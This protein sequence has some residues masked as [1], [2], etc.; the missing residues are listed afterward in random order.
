MGPRHNPL[1]LLTIHA[2]RWCLKLYNRLEVE[3]VAHVPAGAAIVVANHPSAIDPVVLA[4]TLPRRRTLFVAAA[5]F[6]ALPV[7]GWAMRSYGVIPVW[8]GQTDLSVIKDAIRALEDGKLVVIFPEGRVTP[9]GR[10][11]VKS[12]AALLAARARVP[13]LPVALVGTE[14]ALPLGRYIPRPA[15]IRAV[16]GPPLAPPGDRESAERAVEEALAWVRT[17]T[18]QRS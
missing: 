1:V 13:I 12:G 2:A 11:P 7:V 10:G 14:R 16:I 18:A 5:E 9:E 8:R 15:R 6:L 3:G 17:V 4:I